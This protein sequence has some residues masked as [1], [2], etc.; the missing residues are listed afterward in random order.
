MVDLP[1]VVGHPVLLVEPE[2]AREE[3]EGCVRILVEQIWHDPLITLW[4][5]LRH[6]PPLLSLAHSLNGHLVEVDR[7]PPTAAARRHLVEGLVSPFHGVLAL[8]ED[9]AQPPSAATVYGHHD[10]FGVL[11]PR[12]AATF[13]ILTNVADHLID[14]GLIE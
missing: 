4:W 9:D 3:F 10:P 8:G 5:I 7:G 14:T 12:R 1:A 6:V 13:D 2:R 11:E